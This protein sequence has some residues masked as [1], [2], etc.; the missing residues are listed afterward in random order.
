M[1]PH[2][3]IFSSKTWA[4]TRTPEQI[5]PRTDFHATLGLNPITRP[6]TPEGL[7]EKVGTHIGK[8]L[9]TFCDM[10][11]PVVRIAPFVLENVIEWPERYTLESFGRLGH[12]YFVYK[13]SYTFTLDV[14]HSLFP[15]IKI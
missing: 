5:T 7:P 10:I 6:R 1:I 3:S 4:H 8:T 14:F 2:H 9:I 13:T 12:S 11:W 15:E